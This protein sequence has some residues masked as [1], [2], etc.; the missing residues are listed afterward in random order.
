MLVEENLTKTNGK[1]LETS[2]KKV[3]GTSF[4]GPKLYRKRWLILL[5]FSFYS[6]TN[7]FQ[8]IQYSIISN[9]I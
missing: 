9:I 3:V 8:W 6:G 5:L 1:E 7:A 2:Q 4:L